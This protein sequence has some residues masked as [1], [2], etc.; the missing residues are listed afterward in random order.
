MESSSAEPTAVEVL[1]AWAQLRQ[2]GLSP[3][4]VAELAPQI[5]GRS[6]AIE[7]LWA[8]DTDGVEM[9]VNFVK[10]AASDVP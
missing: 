4:R 9:A 10:A 5:L 2:L 7:E 1:T 8:V 3:A 6:A